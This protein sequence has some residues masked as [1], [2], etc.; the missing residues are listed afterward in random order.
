[1]EKNIED[2]KSK[3]ILNIGNAKESLIL[4]KKKNVDDFE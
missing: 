1:M 3:R 2:W 4:G